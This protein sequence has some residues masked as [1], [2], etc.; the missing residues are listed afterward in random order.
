[1]TTPG[2]HCALGLERI[3]VLLDEDYRD[4]SKDTSLQINQAC[5]YAH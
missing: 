3:A 1:M 5:C 4:F 2:W